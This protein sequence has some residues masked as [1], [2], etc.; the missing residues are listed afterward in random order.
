MIKLGQLVEAGM[1]P[2]QKIQVGLITEEK[3]EE[4]MQEMFKK[5]KEVL[6]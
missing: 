1:S 4:E 6:E 2:L 5:M 3:A